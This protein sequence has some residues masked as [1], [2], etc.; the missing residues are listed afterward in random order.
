MAPESGGIVIS[1]I[2]IKNNIIIGTRM[3]IYFFTMGNGG[4]YDKVRIL[5]NTLWNVFTT[6]VWF[7]APNKTP[8]GCEMKNNFI[9]VDV[10]NPPGH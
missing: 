10:L 9:Y 5:H 1:N 2:L 8:T 7:R 4:A 3:G 6:P